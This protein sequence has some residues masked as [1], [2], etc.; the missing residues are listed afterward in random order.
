[1]EKDEATSQRTGKTPYHPRESPHQT[2]VNPGTSGKA[3]R[4]RGTPTEKGSLERQEA[5]GQILAHMEKCAASTEQQ[6]RML[7]PCLGAFTYNI[8]FNPDNNRQL[9]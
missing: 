8:S 7:G 5:D 2:L 1:M 3:L 6:T 4:S 9:Y